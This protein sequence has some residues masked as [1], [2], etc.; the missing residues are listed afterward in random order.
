MPCDLVW[1][2][3]LECTVNYADPAIALGLLLMGMGIGAF[4]SREFFRR[5]LKAVV[6]QEIEKKCRCGG[7]LP[8]PASRRP[9]QPTGYFAVPLQGG[10]SPERGGLVRARNNMGM[11]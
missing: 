10:H 3:F 4:L 6:E 7:Y 9:I 11:W 2:K 8:N 5:N 1:V